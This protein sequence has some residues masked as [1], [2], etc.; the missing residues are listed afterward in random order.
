MA[1]PS[2]PTRWPTS[3]R[4]ALTA[5]NTCT[6]AAGSAFRSITIHANPL[7]NWLAGGTAAAGPHSQ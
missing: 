7:A 5:G 4:A 2:M 1:S 3:W 6:L